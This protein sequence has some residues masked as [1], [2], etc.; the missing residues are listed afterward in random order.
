[1]SSKRF[2]A[3]LRLEPRPSRWLLAVL[4]IDHLGAVAALWPLS[5]LPTPLRVLLTLLILLSLIWTL[6]R[7]GWLGSVPAIRRLTWQADGDWLLESGRGENLEAGL[8]PSSY[9][10]PW[11]VVLNLHV[12]GE[13]LTRSL[14]LWRDSLDPQSFRQLRARLKLEGTGYLTKEQQ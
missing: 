8:L 10:H 3:P 13:R 4:L 9:V 14:T 11:L 1:M 6:R 2:A 7:Q 5:L 12:E